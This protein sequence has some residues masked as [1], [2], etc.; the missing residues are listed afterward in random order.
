MN[1][2]LAILT[3]SASSERVEFG[4]ASGFSAG[5]PW[6][7]STGDSYFAGGVGAEIRGYLMTEFGK[8][9]FDNYWFSHGD[10]TLSTDLF[11]DIVSHAGSVLHRY[12]VTLSNGQAGEAQVHSFYGNN[13]YA[14][15]LG[16][17]TIY[18]QNGHPV[19]FHDRYNFN[20]RRYL[21][22]SG[23]RSFNAE[24]RTR[25]VGTAGFF[26]GATPFD[27]NYGKRP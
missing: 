3:N 13:P 5:P 15:S 2:D 9:M 21:F 14:E 6:N 1:D 4:P 19:G 12:P 7:T 11:N 8:A 23:R 16:S 26:R 27:I 10:F 18:Y 22:N 20:W 25:M 24:L 17:A